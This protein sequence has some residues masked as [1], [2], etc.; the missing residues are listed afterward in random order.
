MGKVVSS[1]P[2][3]TKGLTMSPGIQCEWDRVM[4]TDADPGELGSLDG[5]CGVPRTKGHWKGMMMVPSELG[6][7]QGDRL[8]PEDPDS[9]DL[10]TLEGDSAVPKTKGHQR[11]WC[12]QDLAVLEGTDGCL[13]V[14]ALKSW[15]TWMGTTVSPGSRDTGRGQ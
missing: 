3:D 8:M 4:P 10:G 7:S 1:G 2:R 9:R 6:T 11:G 15:E 5:N 13:W 14:P 12:P